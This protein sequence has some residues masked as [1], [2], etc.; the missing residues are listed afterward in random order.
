MFSILTV[1]ASSVLIGA[2]LLR[3]ERFDAGDG[4]VP[5]PGLAGE[6]A[7]TLVFAMGWADLER[8]GL[9]EA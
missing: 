7:M 1:L 3:A 8:S 6:S 9:S 4:G 5:S 2:A